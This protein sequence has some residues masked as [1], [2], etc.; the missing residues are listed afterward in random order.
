MLKQNQATVNGLALGAGAGLLL[1]VHECGSRQMPALL[2]AGSAGIV[3][4]GCV[5]MNDEA[6][7]MSALP[8][9]TAQSRA[10]VVSNVAK[11]AADS[12]SRPARP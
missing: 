1:Y 5:V 7:K 3:P 9:L 4:A 2:T 6:D 10:A 12:F 11:N 8:A